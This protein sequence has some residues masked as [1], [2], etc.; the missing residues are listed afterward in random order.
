[1]QAEMIHEDST[2]GAKDVSSLVSSI[3]HSYQDDE[4]DEEGQVGFSSP[5]Q[6]FCHKSFRLFQALE[7]TVLKEL[8]IPAFE[9]LNLGSFFS[10]LAKSPPLFQGVQEKCMR[11]LSRYSFQKPSSSSAEN[12]HGAGLWRTSSLHDNENEYCDHGV[13]AKEI[14][15]QFSSLD[16]D[17]DMDFLQVLNIVEL[18]TLEALGAESFFVSTGK[19]F[20]SFMQEV[21]VNYDD[22]ELNNEIKFHVNNC[23]R[24]SGVDYHPILNE[25]DGRASADASAI[26]DILNYAAEQCMIGKYF[27]HFEEMRQHVTQQLETCFSHPQYHAHLPKVVSRLSSICDAVG[28]DAISYKSNA[29]LRFDVTRSDV[30][31][32]TPISETALQEVL[33]RIPVGKRVSDFVNWDATRF[34]NLFQFIIGNESSV[35]MQKVSDTRVFVPIS[36]EDCLVV[37]ASLPSS[38][39]L[40]SFLQMKDYSKISSYFVSANQNIFD[41]DAFQRILHDIFLEIKCSSQFW[42][43]QILE[44]IVNTARVSPVQFQKSVYSISFALLVQV[45][46][47]KSIDIEEQLI[48]ML[49]NLGRS[50]DD[51]LLNAYVLH[52]TAICHQFDFFVSINP[53]ILASV[54]QISVENKTVVD[55]LNAMPTIMVKEIEDILSNPADKKD[56]VQMEQLIDDHQLL[57]L[58]PLADDSERSIVSE[59]KHF[60]RALL[61]REFSYSDDGSGILVPPTKVSASDR[62][63]KSVLSQVQNLNSSNAHFV[64][65]MVQNADDNMYHDIVKPTIKIE[66]YPNAV[67][68]YNNEIGFQEENINAICSAGE[69]TKKYSSGYIGQKGIG[70]KSVFRISNSPEIHSNGYHIMFDREKNMIE[71]I[72]LEDKRMYPPQLKDEN[73]HDFVTCFRLNL[74]ATALKL[75]NFKRLNNN[76]AEVF[77]EKILLLL[78]KLEAMDFDDKK[79]NTCCSLSKRTVPN[80]INWVVLSAIRGR[81]GCDPESISSSYWFVKRKVINPPLHRKRADEA[82]PI[83]ATKVAIAFK[84]L[85]YGSNVTAD[86]DDD[87]PDM[88]STS[89]SAAFASKKLKPRNSEIRLD[90]REVN[91]PIYAFL[92]TKLS[93][94]QFVVQGD[95]VLN[96]SRESLNE[97]SSWN[98]LLFDSIIPL[99]IETVVEMSSWI[100]TKPEDRSRYCPG[101]SQLG[102]QGNLILRP[103]DLVRLLPKR[104][105]GSLLYDRVIGRIYE[106]LRCIPFLPNSD[107]ILVPCNQLV[108]LNVSYDIKA[109]IPIKIF[110]DA[111]G[112]MFL[113]TDVELSDTLAADLHISRITIDMVIR[114]L[115]FIDKMDD[116]SMKV[117]HAAGCL[118]L[119]SHIIGATQSIAKTSIVSTKKSAGII[120]SQ[121]VKKEFKSASLVAAAAP[122]LL[123]LSQKEK[124]RIKKLKI[125]PVLQLSGKKSLV[126]LEDNLLYFES[127][128]HPMDSFDPTLLRCIEIFHNF[129]CL[130]HNSMYQ[131]AQR[132]F[133][134]GKNVIENL[135]AKFFCRPLPSSSNREQGTDPKYV[136]F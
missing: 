71:P 7:Q 107:G 93:I 29:L 17:S 96:A 38:V 13:F 18:S 90:E 10:F 21:Y 116:V 76:I 94:F 109:L 101:L 73:Q 5:Q 128:K 106:Q 49:K 30:S 104:Q 79:N 91:F 133:E 75:E 23:L 31:S 58:H 40:N 2:K 110:Q 84:F 97:D 112:L 24:S 35:C 118:I 120:L 28:H 50:G 42:I 34:G 26:V 1:M 127:N 56:D 82:T 27:E 54:L 126:S 89:P 37:P 80:S 81:P 39:E 69:S 8:N 19:S 68:V 62:K 55:S 87:D 45:S 114:C 103:S 46:K 20:L 70:F 125:W 61:V 59:R 22:S 51:V 53:G 66:L 33:S 122:K 3:L 48:E 15:N 47:I 16:Q 9:C 98:E 102:G 131:H 83:V 44:L 119:L 130:L 124:D 6:E 86:D 105:G 67:L 121:V 134:N 85:K 43:F 78:N 123:V 115:E 92:P 88:Q 99:Y 132:K 129:I 111:T 4:E 74:D 95:F 136:C 77:D 64:L 25:S 41:C 11:A 113:S 63:L 36:L 32:D 72:W 117:E 52:L 14:L 60:V 65:E 12:T 100:F 135:I 57:S 108:L